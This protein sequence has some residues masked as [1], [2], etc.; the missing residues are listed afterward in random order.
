MKKRACGEQW[1]GGAPI[2]RIEV[3]RK[4]SLGPM[5]LFASCKKCHAHV[6][7]FYIFI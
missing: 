1:K 5:A 7:Y 3:K 6:D 4:Y 2:K